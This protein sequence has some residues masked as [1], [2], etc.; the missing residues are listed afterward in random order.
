[1]SEIAISEK[2]Y[3][4]V[5]EFKQVVEAVIEE[6]INFDDCVELI[7]GQG[8]DSMLADLLGSVDQTTLL[9]SF[10]QLG[11]EYPGQVYQYVAETLRRGAA[12]QE[13]E[14]M[15]RQLGFP[16]PTREDSEAQ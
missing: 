9:T 11:S 4:R 15:R 16:L 1:M 14:S 10:Q 5:A 6:K 7:L 13:R 3:A 2:M 8:I 12:V